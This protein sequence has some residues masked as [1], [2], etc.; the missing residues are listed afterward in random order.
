[1][2]RQHFYCYT[3]CATLLCGTLDVVLVSVVVVAVA[4]AVAAQAALAVSLISAVGLD[5]KLH[6][7][8]VSVQAALAVA[9][10]AASGL[11]CKLHVADVA[12]LDVVCDICVRDVEVC[13]LIIGTRVETH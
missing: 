4:V 13:E 6:V 7:A 3:A 5:C 8:A 10:I 1:M 2:L 9:V 12:A 11:D